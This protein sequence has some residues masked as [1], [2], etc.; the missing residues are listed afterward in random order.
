MQ[1]NPPADSP[2]KQICKLNPSNV[3]QGCGRTL[4]EIG[5][6]QAASNEERQAILDRI[7][8]DQSTEDSVS[9]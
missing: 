7:A 2:C 6:W 3:C 5:H 4:D 9:A 1:N 8:L